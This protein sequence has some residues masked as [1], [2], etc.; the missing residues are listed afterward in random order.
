MVSVFLERICCKFEEEFTIIDE[1]SAN[2]GNNKNTIDK[3]IN[4]KNASKKFLPCNNAFIKG[5]L[6]LCR[7]TFG[8]S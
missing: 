6:D 5:L 7:K 4:A 2:V 1:G 8:P 3:N